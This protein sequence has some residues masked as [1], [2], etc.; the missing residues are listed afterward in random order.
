MTSRA[1]W[2]EVWNDATPGTESGLRLYMT[3]VVSMSKQ[4]LGSQA[5]DT[6]AQ[7]A[8]T[9]N[10]V[11]QKLGAG[12]GPPHLGLLLDALLTGL[13]GRTWTGK[14][15]LSAFMLTYTSDVNTAHWHQ[16]LMRL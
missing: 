2:E 15:G 3:E 6:K 7:G 4:A 14:V 1:L 5:W 11:A 9:I 10:D 8:A 13:Q 16:S 12:L